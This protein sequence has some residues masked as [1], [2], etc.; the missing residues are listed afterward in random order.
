MSEF[1]EAHRAEFGVEPICT[2][3]QVA[4]SA[5]RLRK[6]RIAEPDLRSYRARSDEQALI[7]IRRVWDESGQLYGVRKVWEQ[8]KRD[9]VEIPRCQVER[10]M[11][12]HGLAGVRRDKRIRTTVSDPKVAS[13]TDLVERKFHA[14]HPNQ[15]WVS[16]FT[17]VSTWSGFV[18]VAFVVDV[19]ARYIVGWKVSYSDLP[20]FFGPLV[21]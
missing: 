16:D 18:Y 9:L 3:L 2:V 1:I 21:T 20:P 10:L 12:K 13:P 7:Q 8:L 17:Y 5:Y 6:R 14:G 4:S 19:Y 11:R 15:L